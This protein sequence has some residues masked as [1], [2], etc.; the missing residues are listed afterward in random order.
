MAARVIAI[1]S[2]KGGVGKTVTS[3]NLAACLAARGRRTLVIDLDPQGQSA[4][5]LGVDLSSRPRTTYDLLV[6]RGVAVADVAQR[7]SWPALSS[8]AVIPSTLQ[9]A[10][11]ERELLDGEP[12]PNL[13]LARKLKDARDDWDEIILDCPPALNVLTLNAFL[14]ADRML[15]PM[16]VGFFSVHGVRLLEDALED[17][18]EQTGLDLH[19]HCVVTRF[20]TRQ[21][22]SREVLEAA[23]EMFGARLVETVIHECIDVER[24]VGEQTPLVVGRPKSRAA[25]D[26]AALAGEVIA[27]S[28]D[29]PEGEGGHDA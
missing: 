21:T 7:V 20:R 16:G 8:L 26:Y 9:L 24:A 11:A 27:W 3:V 14:A 23:G 13:A 22:V 29:E 17:L 15:L 19:S 25:R 5:G 28:E 10:L 18:R 1:A 4:V 12:A 6:D 2:Q